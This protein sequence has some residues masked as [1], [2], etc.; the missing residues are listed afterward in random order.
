MPHLDSLVIATHN[1]GKAK[2][3]SALLGPY[4]AS[5]QTA[6]ELNLPE[7]EETGLSFAENAVIKAVTAAQASGKPALADDSGLCVNALD[8]A[9]GIYSA[10]W[11]GETKN[12]E[13]A[14]ARIHNAIDEAKSEDRGAKFVCALALAFPDGSH[15]V[16]EGE[17][18]GTIVLPHAGHTDLGMTLFSSLAVI[19]SR[20]VRCK[21][22]KRTLCLTAAALLR[23][24]SKNFLINKR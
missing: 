10:R 16:F 20:S 7:P 23:Y 19:R 11:A 22:T 2:E 5:F 21:P 1:A 8:G 13:I 4:V 14:M 9:P 15:H 3:I 12:F 17:V 6:G 18:E 24:S